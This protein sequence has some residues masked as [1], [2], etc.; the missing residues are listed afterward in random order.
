MQEPIHE[1]YAKSG[2]SYADL[3]TL[4]GVASIKQMGGPTIGWSSG[5][6]DQLVDFV[7]ANKVLLN[8][9]VRN[10]SSL[11]DKGLKALINYP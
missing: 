8:A 5:R 7:T 11:L 2:L 10:N 3:Y 4:A 6:R 1:K 9:L